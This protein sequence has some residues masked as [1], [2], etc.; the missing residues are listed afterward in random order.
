MPTKTKNLEQAHIGLSKENRMNLVQRLNKLLA[1]EHLLYTKTR[2]Y[3]WNV[4]GI[5]FVALHELFEAHYNRLQAM[6][7]EIAERNRMLGGMSIGTMAEFL[8]LTRLSETAGTVPSSTDMIAN[9]LDDHEH[10][11]SSLREDITACAEEF[12]DEGTADLL[13]G[14]MRSHEE[15]AW[16]LRSMTNGNA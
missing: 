12:N 14:T 6:A 4:T 8:D 5:H 2:N 1:D 3:H 11:I 7:D 10:I 15:M 16:M 9:L 13:I